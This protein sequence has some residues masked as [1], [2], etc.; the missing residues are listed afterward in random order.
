MQLEKLR[1]KV[2][3]KEF[4]RLGDS[5]LNCVASMVLTLLKG[6]P[7][8][9]RVSNKDLREAY[10]ELMLDHKLGLKRLPR[11][12]NP[13]DIVEALAGVMWL[14]GR[15]NID[16]ITDKAFKTLKD[17]HGL[18]ESHVVKSIAKILAEILT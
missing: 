18:S 3:S 2:L 10:R 8:G 6:K 4:A 9:V 1:K 15:L 14:E 16:E 12:I 5:I 7:I 13:E 11:G 17:L